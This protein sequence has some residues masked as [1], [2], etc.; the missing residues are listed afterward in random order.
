MQAETE[1]IDTLESLGIR[2]AKADYWIAYRLN[3]LFHER[4]MFTPNSAI[5]DRQASYSREF[6]AEPFVAYVFHASEPRER[7]ETYERSFRLSHVPFERREVD[8]FTVLILNTV[9]FVYSDSDDE[10][11]L[12][13]VQRRSGERPGRTAARR[14][15]EKG[16]D[17][18]SRDRLAGLNRARKP[19]EVVDSTCA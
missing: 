19:L 5:E 16:G 15:F 18:I 3:Y 13:I 2:A 14:V 7:P 10:G 17:R 6:D 4:I 9:S 12:T 8:G 1:L 11:I